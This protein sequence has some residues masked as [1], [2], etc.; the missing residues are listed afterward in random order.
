[1]K[2]IL[3]ITFFA[4]ATLSVSAAIKLPAIFSD[5]MVIQRNAPVKIW[6]WSTRNSSIEIS[7]NGQKIKLRSDRNGL[8][9]GTLRPMNHGG[10]FEM[11]ILN[12]K[13]NIVLNNILIGDVWLGSGQ[14]NMEWVVRNSDDAEKEIS[15]GNY[16]KIRLFTVGKKMSY[17]PLEDIAGGP[18]EICS[19]STVEKFSA[20]AYFFGRKLYQELEIP[21]G[22]INSSWGGTNI[23]TWISWDVMSL[24][25][26]FKN[27]DMKEHQKMAMESESRAEKY[28]QALKTDPGIDEK[29]YDI[30]NASASWKRMELPQEWGRT[31]LGKSDGIVWFRKEITLPVNIGD[32]KSLL[33]LGPIDDWDDTYINGQLI[34]STMDYSQDR[35]Y[36]LGPGVLKE[37]TNVIV[38]KVTDTGGGGGMNGRKEQ[39]F[40]EV[41]GERL[42][43]N[44]EWMYK[45][46]VLNTDF[47]VQQ[48][49]PNSFPSQLY[50]AMIAPIT[51][52]SIKGVIWYQGESNAGNPKKYRTLFPAL[53]KDWRS[54]WG[55][56]FPF[57]WVQLAN[58]MAPDNEP[59]E[60]SWAELRESQ[61]ATLSVPLTGQALAIDIGVA[62]DIHPRNKQDV[63]LRLALNAL[64]ITYGKDIVST[65]PMY[66]S[67]EKD[68]SKMI[69]SFTGIGSGLQAKGDRYGYLRGFAIAGPDKKFVWAKA[70]IKNDK[71]IVYS[72]HVTDPVAVRY[73]WADN[74][75]DANLYN[76]EGLPACPFRTDY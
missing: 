41:E 39:M 58:F 35:Q 14:S 55:S 18:W 15:T 26:E 5:N 28:R 74:P 12:G 23:E 56:D 6:G 27:L 72:H 31:E 4:C 49:G 3:L 43:L 1:M 68:G 9:I 64:R 75:D 63:G 20:V 16:E 53:I 25:E 76:K 2:K 51:S 71:V 48:T 70:E 73:A 42:A 50:H 34:G 54:R 69:L 57:L 13:E 24:D 21:I 59:D 10:P 36:P 7:F 47:G 11:K 65:G 45:P 8:W 62:N 67:A 32:K 17:V 46:S 40:I 66:K 52:F 29:W 38:V 44:G 37:G 60:S 61:T 30:A 33:S 22:L 19:S